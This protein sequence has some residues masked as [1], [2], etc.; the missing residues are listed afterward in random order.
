MDYLMPNAITSEELRHKVINE[1]RDEGYV[2]VI[3]SPEEL[4]DT[5]VDDLEDI[6]IERGN[7]FIDYSQQ[8]DSTDF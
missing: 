3:W 8:D 7:N 4:G 2:I 1:M 6:V 5:N